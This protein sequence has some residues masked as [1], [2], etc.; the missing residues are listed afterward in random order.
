MILSTTNS[1]PLDFEITPPTPISK[2]VVSK[3]NKANMNIARAKKNLTK[4]NSTPAALLKA[5][6]NS[7]ASTE[8]TLKILNLRYQELV[9]EQKSNIASL[10]QQ[11]TN[12]KITYSPTALRLSVGQKTL[13][14]A[15]RRIMF[16]NK[17]ASRRGY[18]DW[19]LKR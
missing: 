10:E 1:E 12:F 6:S 14:K 4:E 7:T 2:N 8:D 3:K 9:L 11:K 18:F 13:R 19:K 16:I 5:V 17:R 15:P